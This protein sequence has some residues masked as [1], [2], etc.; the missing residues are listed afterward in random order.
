MIPLSGLFEGD[1]V[2]Q[3]FVVGK[4]DTLNQLAEKL[5]YHSVDRRVAKQDRPFEVLIKGEVFPGDV[6]VNEVGL[7]PMDHLV[8]RYAPL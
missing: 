1:F 2:A 5:A 6:K 7:T 8:V 4:E 3:L